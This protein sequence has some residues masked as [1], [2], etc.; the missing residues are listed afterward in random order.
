MS[1]SLVILK[2]PLVS[3]I[4]LKFTKLF[5][6]VQI[7]ILKEIH[8]QADAFVRKDIILMILDFVEVRAIPIIPTGISTLR[9][10]FA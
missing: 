5:K 7:Q 4:R 3:A 10:V 2:L 6:N 1:A 8:H 9:N